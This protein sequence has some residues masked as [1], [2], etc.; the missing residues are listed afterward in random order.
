MP[1]GVFVKIEPT[2]KIHSYGPG[3]RA[4]DLIRDPLNH[5]AA[6]FQLEETQ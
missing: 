5:G 4:I 6:S 2:G 3:A 1:D